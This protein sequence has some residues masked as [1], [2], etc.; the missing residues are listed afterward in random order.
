M[1]TRYTET[2][3]TLTI[4]GD[5]RD[6]YVRGFV[7]VNTTGATLDGD[8]DVR[9]DGDWW[10]VDAVNVGAGDR[11]RIEEALCEAAFTDDRDS[12]VIECSS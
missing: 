3:V 9:T 2:E 4:E 12:C 8:P 7:D 10:P 11:D 1:S 5:E 6:V